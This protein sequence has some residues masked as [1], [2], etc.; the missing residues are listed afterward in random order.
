MNKNKS[1]S[2]DSNDKKLYAKILTNKE[3]KIDFE[4]LKTIFK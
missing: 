2:N 1:I 4:A 3:Y